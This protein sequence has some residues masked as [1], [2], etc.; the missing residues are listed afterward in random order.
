[1]NMGYIFSN[2][3]N[4]AKIFVGNLNNDILIQYIS[5]IIK[6]NSYK[7]FTMKFEENRTDAKFSL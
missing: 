7:I 5:M 4:T 2:K 1:M 3:I 6:S